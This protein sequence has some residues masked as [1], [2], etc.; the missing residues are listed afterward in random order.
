MAR[1]ALAVL[2]AAGIDAAHVI[3]ASMGG[4]IAQELALLY[5]HRVRSLILACTSY[6]GLFARWPDPRFARWLIGSKR[7][8]HGQER[9]LTNLLYADTTPTARINE[10]IEIRCACTWTAAG[11]FNQFAGILLWNSYYRLPRITAPTLVIHGD[12]DR[13]I[14]IQN[15][16]T[17]AKRIPNARFHVIPNAGHILMTDQPELCR[18]GLAR[19]LHQQ[20]HPLTRAGSG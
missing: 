6:S 10:D 8:R 9:A 12:Q 3:G 14:P 18:E 16:R 2:D 11:F 17:V 5:P 13:L 7:T 4:M 1:D 19:F 15:G 20:T